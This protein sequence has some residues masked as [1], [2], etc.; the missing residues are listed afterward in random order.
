MPRN[1]LRGTARQLWGDEESALFCINVVLV[2]R[3]MPWTFYA[4]RW[5][6]RS[7]VILNVLC[8]GQFTLS[9]VSFVRML[10]F[11]TV[12]GN[13]KKTKQRSNTHWS[14]IESSGTPWRFFPDMLSLKIM[15]WAQI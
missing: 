8:R 5:V 7:I 10:S 6:F 1:T 9:V 4:Q 3:Y 12:A 14:M 13:N 11:N 15:V 2:Y